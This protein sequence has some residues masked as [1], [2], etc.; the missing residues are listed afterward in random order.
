V[1]RVGLLAVVVLGAALISGCGAGGSVR[2]SEAAL[3][4][5]LRQNGAQVYA[6]RTAQERAITRE[7]GGS[8]KLIGAQFP[9]GEWMGFFVAPNSSRASAIVSKLEDLQRRGIGP[10]KMS[11]MGNLVVLAVEHS[12]KGVQNVVQ[13]CERQRPDDVACRTLADDLLRHLADRNVRGRNQAAEPV[14]GVDLRDV[15]DVDH[16]RPRCPR[17]PCTPLRP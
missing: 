2:Y 1:E 14:G 5:C 6:P 4:A 13:S 16:R 10:G 11:Q 15:V 7:I 9:S 3:S 17:A 12:T 8:S